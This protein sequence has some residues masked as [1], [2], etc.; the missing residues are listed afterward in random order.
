MDQLPRETI[1]RYQ[2]EIGKSL[3]PIFGPAPKDGRKPDFLVVPGYAGKEKIDT[4][5]RVAPKRDN[6][7]SF[8]LGIVREYGLHISSFPIDGPKLLEISKD[9]FWIL[10]DRNI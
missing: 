1:I 6:P 10:K 8:M 5:I 4:E 7:N 3:C 2:N 9:G